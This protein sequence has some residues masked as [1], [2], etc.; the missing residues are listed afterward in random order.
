[1][2]LNQKKFQKHS[3]VSRWVQYRDCV[4]NVR[5]RLAP[6]VDTAH[7]AVQ[8]HE[9]LIL[10]HFFD[11][12]VAFE[13]YR[14]KHQPEVARA[15]GV[16]ELMANAAE[17]HFLIQH[18]M[19][20]GTTEDGFKY[21]WNPRSDD[22][23]GT[24]NGIIAHVQL[25]GEEHP[26]KYSV[27]CHHYGSTAFSSKGYSPDILELFSY[28]ILELLNV[29][30]AVQFILPSSSTGGKTSTYIASIW[31]D[32]FIRQ[33][34]LSDKND[35]S[36][37]ALIQL[38]LLNVLFFIGDLH[39]DNCGQWKSTDR[40]AVVD[41]I[42]LPYATY[43]DVK[44]AVRSPIKLPWDDVPRKLLLEY[45]EEK[46][47]D[48]ARES[49]GDWNVLENIKLANELIVKEKSLMKKLE[50]DFRGIDSESN[51]T[52]TNDLENH[53]DAIKANIEKLSNELG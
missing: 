27:K 2:F 8:H 21:E 15:D 25:H 23:R 18:G 13:D 33:S 47:W 40:A 43:P 51:Y 37:K 16:V 36:I 52:V 30:P 39:G 34:D 3:E 45:N 7:R 19:R 35:F 41:L 28:K 20:G 9:I 42:P 5:K 4:E 44:R 26:T 11:A 12:Y 50:I 10:S 29:G 49:L 31:R 32:D 48:L 46:F 53:M 14:R 17:N 24:R 1:M 38:R 6:D 22:M